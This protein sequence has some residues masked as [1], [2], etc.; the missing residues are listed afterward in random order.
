MGHQNFVG[1]II[2]PSGPPY[3]AVTLR[4]VPYVSR[5]VDLSRALRVLQ[6]SSQIW[7]V[8]RQPVAHLVSLRLGH[9][10]LHIN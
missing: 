7:V 3:I 9:V 2:F 8:W 6:F 10:E 1:N 5:V 4:L